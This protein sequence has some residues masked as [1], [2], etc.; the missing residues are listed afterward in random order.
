MYYT[1]GR[2]T[3]DLDI[4]AALA[5]I[6]VR[7]ERGRP[8]RTFV[9]GRGPAV[10][11]RFEA[12]SNCGR[13]RME[14][15][16]RTWN[17][18]RWMAGRAGHPW[19][20]LRAACGNRQAL[21]GW[22]QGDG[23]PLVAVR[24]GNGYRLRPA[25]ETPAE[26]RRHFGGLRDDAPRHAQGVPGGVSTMDLDVAAGMLALG[27]GL[28]RGREWGTGMGPR[29]P[30]R[31]L[32]LLPRSDCGTMEAHAVAEAWEDEEW[33]TSHEDHPLSYVALL[34][35]NRA[36]LMDFV[37]RAVPIGQVE[38]RGKTGFLPLDAPDDRQRVFFAE[39]RRK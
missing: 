37:R 39:L 24:E 6:G 21:V 19:A 7:L 13:F 18:D 1:R 10:L 30:R 8:S 22:V 34:G 23:A 35:K 32:H 2:E 36:R 14:S 31:V 20:Y 12:R 9:G 16:C 33:L 3:A 27:F 26:A 17:D 4:A 29:G 25:R 11:F 28:V 5:T 15:L 38:C